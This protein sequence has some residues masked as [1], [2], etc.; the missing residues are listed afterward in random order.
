MVDRGHPTAGADD[1]VFDVAIIGSGFGGLG[2]AQ[3]L[4]ADGVD[5]F[6]VLEQADHV[7]GTW[8]D[9][10]YPGAACDVPAHLYSYSF[11]RYDWSRRYPP[12][13]EILAYIDDVVATYDLARH[14][15]YGFAVDR[16]TFDQDRALWT[17]VSRGGESVRARVV[18]SSVGQLNRPRYPEIPGR[19]TF[20]GASWHSAR[21]DH[22]HDLRGKRVAVIGT[23]ASAIQFV[24]EVAKVAAEVR[25]FQRNAPYV[26]PKADRAY[27]RRDRTLYA[28]LPW[29]EKLDRASIFARGELLTTA[30]LGS[31]LSR[32]NVEKMWRTHLDEQ[33]TDPDLRA[34]CIPDFVVGCNRIL[35]SND[36]YPALASPHVELV[37]D[38][39]TDI[40]PEGVVTEDPVSEDTTHHEVDVIIYGTGFAATGF[41]Q[42]M[43][44]IGRDGADL[45][46]RWAHGAAAYRGVAVPGFPNFF[47]L[48]GPNTNLGGNSIIYMLEAQIGYIA[49]GLAEMRRLDLDTIEVRADEADEFASW[50][51]EQ[52]ESTAWVTNCH[53]WYTTEGHNTNNWPALT[54]RYRRLMDR[55][56]LFAYQARPRPSG[57]PPRS[58]RPDATLVGAVR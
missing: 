2:M 39:I 46:G 29:I 36:W 8:R 25:V 13:E 58:S 37:T 34:K 35:F 24:P 27:S 1:H 44:V 49:Q 47:V 56:E 17:V 45:Q 14:L 51:A 30:I 57:A 43:E 11:H 41:L 31:D 38:P 50:V 22:E 6:V 55:F 28:R 26:I 7:G 52:S 12:H 9:N 16:A 42:P 21:W 32:A 54:F 40:V 15:R 20:A 53:S 48:Y 19:D 5:D 3:R 10:T 18:V 4:R 33:I 23:G